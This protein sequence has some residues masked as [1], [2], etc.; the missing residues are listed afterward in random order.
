MRTG[1]QKFDWII[2]DIN[3]TM[4]N[5]SKVWHHSLK[6]KKKLLSQNKNNIKFN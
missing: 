2:V 5:R 6:I 1:N 4:T 3:G